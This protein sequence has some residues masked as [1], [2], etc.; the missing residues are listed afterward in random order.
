MRACSIQTIQARVPADPAKMPLSSLSSALALAFAAQLAW[1]GPTGGQVVAGAATISTLP[2]SVV[3]DQSSHRA[4]VNWQSFSIHAGE[5][6][7]FNLPSS[8]A[9]VLNRVVANNPSAIYGNLSSNGQVFLI[10]PHGIVVGPSGVINAA[11]FVASTRD[12]SNQQF[13]NGGGLDFQGNSAAPVQNLGRIVAL[14]GDAALIGARV[15]NVGAIEAPRGTVALVA[16]DHVYYAPDSTAFIVV[17]SGI[18]MAEGATG[19]DNSGLIQAAQAELRAAGGN[20]LALAVNNTGIVSATRV[21]TIGGRVILSGGDGKTQVAGTVSARAGATG[22]EIQALGQAVTVKSGALLDASGTSG[23][24]QILVGGDYQGKNAAVANAQNTTVEAGTW[25]RADALA[26]GNGGRVIV[27]ADDATDYRGAISARGGSNGG[28]GGFAEVSGKQSLLFRG[29]ADLRAP[30]GLTGN[31][32]LDPTDITIG[33]AAATSVNCAAGTCSGSGASSFLHVGDL[34]AALGFSNVTVTTSSGGGGAGDI[35]I[36]SNI[37]QWATGLIAGNSL[38]LDAERDILVNGALYLKR[39]QSTDPGSPTLTL[40]AGRNLTIAPDLNGT[41]F[42]NNPYAVIGE[43]GL[44]LVAGRTDSSG[45]LTIGANSNIGTIAELSSGSFTGGPIRVF[46]VAAGQ[47]TLTGWSGA[48]SAAVTGG[49]AFGDAGT[50]A[51]GIYYQ[52]G[53][54]SDNYAP[55]ANQLATETSN[56]PA[57]TVATNPGPGVFNPIYVQGFDLAQ[58][59]N[60]MRQEVSA[61][62]GRVLFGS[63]VDALLTVTRWIAEASVPP[64]ARKRD[65]YAAL[66]AAL[67][68]G[69]EQT[70]P[71]ER[72]ASDRLIY[73]RLQAVM[74]G[75]LTNFLSFKHPEVARLMPRIQASEQKLGD[76]KRARASL[77]QQ[78]VGVPN[79]MGLLHAGS[80]SVMTLDA[81]IAAEERNLAAMRQQYESV[82]TPQALLS[83]YLEYYT[84]YG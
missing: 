83:F 8:A 52:E 37:N 50:A 53:G 17:K 7:R 45:T 18:S 73:Q 26:A 66:L 35:T 25:L 46:G 19:V 6:A 47:T 74:S 14:D 61:S 84:I 49:K 29:T 3:V 5:S 20:P 54:A 12:V 16:G 78:D 39:S 1:A 63:D 77:L 13:M 56:V 32:L 11:G 76:L 48:A 30:L 80:D 71:G 64:G 40:L 69:I 9:A 55:I 10:N 31:L 36:D 2:G 24:G 43:K 81:A 51:A 23:G 4:I 33:D 27:W 72:S 22:G 62:G 44:T 34:Q 21:D 58:V 82:V 79:L 70:P 42:Y 38:T 15:E 68:E 41:N 28:H 75:A 59:F 65:T 60:T 57:V 67:M